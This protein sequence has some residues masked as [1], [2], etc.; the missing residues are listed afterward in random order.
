MVRRRGRL[1]ESATSRNI[2]GNVHYKKSICNGS[3]WIASANKAKDMIGTGNI[4][5]HINQLHPIRIVPARS[6]S[7]SP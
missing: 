4:E 7:T 3:D 2:T 1:S 6:L 5:T